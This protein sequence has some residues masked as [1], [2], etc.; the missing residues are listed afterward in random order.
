[1]YSPLTS[2][3]AANHHLNWLGQ[4]LIQGFQYNDRFCSFL[5]TGPETQ[6]D[7]EEEKEKE[8]EKDGGR[9]R[10]RTEEGA[11]REMERKVRFKEKEKRKIIPSTA[12]TCEAEQEDR[13][14]ET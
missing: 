9:N 8:E 12:P 1:M 7:E 4:I 6:Q 5:P 10:G 2:T 11:K 3:N 14:F 13:K